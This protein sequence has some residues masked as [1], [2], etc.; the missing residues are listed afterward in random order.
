[1]DS[2]AVPARGSVSIRVCGFSRAND[3]SPSLR[4][5]FRFHALNRI[6]RPSGCSFGPVGLAPSGAFFPFAFMTKAAVKD[7]DVSGTKP[8]ETSQTNE[9]SGPLWK[10]Q[11]G[12][13]QGAMWKHDQSEKARY[14]VSISRSYKDE[15]NKWQSVHYFDSQDL[16][17]VVSIAREAEEKIL[18][19][20]EMTTE[21]GED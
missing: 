6:V 15:K 7:R 3:V 9:S 11:H 1:M 19:L 21:A 4:A 10:K 14:T 18:E 8:E 13:V 17:D 20:K 16:S 12:R 2:C 5:L